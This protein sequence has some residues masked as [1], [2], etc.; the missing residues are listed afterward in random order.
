MCIVAIVTIVNMYFN[1]T[2]N[3]FIMSFNMH[4]ESLCFQ[5][6]ITECLNYR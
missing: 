1:Y 3:Y 5:R 4:L 2:F 6:A